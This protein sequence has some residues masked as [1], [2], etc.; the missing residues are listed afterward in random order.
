MDKKTGR[1]KM[2][3]ITEKEKNVIQNIAESEYQGTRGLN[4]LN[5][6]LYILY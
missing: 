3:N 6:N 4:E 5:R 1:E 2:I